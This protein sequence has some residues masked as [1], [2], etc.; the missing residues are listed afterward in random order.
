MACDAASEVNQLVDVIDSNS[1]RVRIGYQEKWSLLRK[2]AFTIIQNRR[3][4]K[5][6]F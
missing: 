2:L 6:M 4:F 5:K 1:F 3:L